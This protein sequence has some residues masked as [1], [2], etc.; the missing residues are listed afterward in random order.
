MYVMYFGQLMDGTYLQCIS[1][2]LEYYL[3]QH[4][5]KLTLGVGTLMQ[6]HLGD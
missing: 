2:H 4:K 6:E 5:M 3:G 1:L